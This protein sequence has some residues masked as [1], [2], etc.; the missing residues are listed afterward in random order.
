[1]LLWSPILNS[2]L[3]LCIP[4]FFGHC[5]VNKYVVYISFNESFEVCLVFLIYQSYVFSA[6]IAIIATYNHRAAANF[7][8]QHSCYFFTCAKGI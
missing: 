5:Y 4:V 7:G 8:K 6:A 3:M 2:Q 1:M